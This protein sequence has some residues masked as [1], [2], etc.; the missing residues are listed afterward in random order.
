M[1]L[2]LSI[3]SDIQVVPQGATVIKPLPTRAEWGAE[4]FGVCGLV[5][6]LAVQPLCKQLGATRS[7]TQPPHAC[8]FPMSPRV[9][10]SKVGQLWGKP[11]ALS[12]EKV[13]GLPELIIGRS[14]GDI[15]MLPLFPPVATL[16]FEV[17]MFPDLQSDSRRNRAHYMPWW[18]LRDCPTP[19]SERSWIRDFWGVA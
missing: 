6:P 5:V 16:L 8:R 14:P 3:V 13:I 15:G 2:G 11:L 12:L 18:K 19:P 1:G 10:S 7:W 9:L 17:S 4:V